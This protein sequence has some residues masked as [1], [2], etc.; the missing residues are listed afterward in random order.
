LRFGSVLGQHAAVPHDRCPVAE[1]FALSVCH[2]DVRKNPDLLISV[3]ERLVAIHGPERIPL[4]VLAGHRGRG[5]AEILGRIRSS[6]KVEGRVRFLERVT[7]RTLGMLYR[8]ALFMV[9]ASRAE[10]WGL[11]VAEALCHGKAVICSNATSLPEVGGDL[12]DYFHPDDLD[13]AYRLIERA[14]FEP[15]WREARGDRVRREFRPRSWDESFE[16]MLVAIRS[17]LSQHLPAIP[18][19]AAVT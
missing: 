12:C 19:P 11:P 3:W 2:L 15:R 16:E 10:G 5:A 1:P 18:T 4:L 8:D 14:I 17:H 9:F 13:G 6:G 7:D